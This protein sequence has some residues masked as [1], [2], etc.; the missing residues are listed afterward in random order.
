MLIY[1]RN[2][3]VAQKSCNI[4]L[5]IFIDYNIDAFENFSQVSLLFAGSVMLIVSKK[6]AIS[7]LTIQIADL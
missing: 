6:R 3:L 2:G 5:T 1:N 4:F 7:T